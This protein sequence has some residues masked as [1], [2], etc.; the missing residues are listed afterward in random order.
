[1]VLEFLF[2]KNNQIYQNLQEKLEESLLIS[3]AMIAVRSKNKM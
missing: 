2:L 3:K 1:M